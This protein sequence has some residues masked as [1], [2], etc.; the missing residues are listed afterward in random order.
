MSC[1][2]SS[3]ALPRLLATGGRVSCLDSPQA[4]LRM[5]AACGQVSHL[6][7][8]GLALVAGFHRPCPG[9]WLRVDR[10]WPGC[11]PRVDRCHR[12]CPGCWIPRALPKSSYALP[13]LLAAGGLV[14]CL[15]S[16]GLGS[17]VLPMSLAA[18]PQAFPRSLAIG[19]CVS[20]L[21]AVRRPCS[22]RWPWVDSVAPG[23][24]R[25]FP[26]RGWTGVALGVHMPCPRHWISQVF[27][28]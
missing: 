11:W 14:S 6:D 22:D 12:S 13:R 28:R 7:S 3:Q 18:G 1:L 9:C 21:E 20:R 23:F 10:P 16:T 2:D 15:E 24:H 27:P 8:T 25:P 19:G 26:G 17:T 5:L 4:L